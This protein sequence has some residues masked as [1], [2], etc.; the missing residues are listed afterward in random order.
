MNGAKLRPVAFKWRGKLNDFITST[1]W[2]PEGD[3]L[4]AGAVSG[5]VSIYEA[6]TGRAIHFFEQAHADGCDAVAWRPDGKALATAG[7]DGK[8]KLWDATGGKIIAEHEAGALW[9]EHLAWSRHPI[10]DKGHLLALGAGNKVTLWTGTGTAA[11]EAMAFPKTVAAV[12][13][14]PD[15]MTLAAA[16]STGVSQRNPLTGAEERAF[17]SRDPI[18]S[19]A[20]SPSGKWLMTGNQDCTVH[21]WNTEGGAEMHMRGYAAKVR[22]LA[23]HRGSRWLATGG[24]PAVSVWDCSGRGPEGRMPVILDWHTDQ[25]SALHYQPE[26]DWLASG[27]RDGGVAVWSPTQR[28][29]LITAAKIPSGVTQVAWSPSGKLLAATGEAGEVQMLE[30]E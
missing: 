18:L 19:M 14:I 6:N 7:R 8:W 21:V 30:L 3:R 26:G 9:A 4:A 20:F 25:V 23:W 15:G 29:T 16:Y 28:Q 27:A 22:Q 5:Q 24:G 2:S 10:G 12:A 13:W 1:A 11:G 17:A